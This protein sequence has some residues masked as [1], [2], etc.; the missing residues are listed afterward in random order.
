IAL[1]AHHVDARERHIDRTDLKWHDV[2]AESGERERND[3]KKHHDCAMHRAEDV[4][5]VRL[6]RSVRN[7]FRAE[8]LQQELAN[9]GYGLIR[10]S[11]LPSHQRHEQIAEKQEA[12]SGE[13]ILKADHLVVGGENIFP[14]EAN[15]MMIDIM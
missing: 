11:Q 7:L 3:G 12:Q 5:E 10:I 1:I 9:D 8:D 13:T 15:L 2:V 14:P 6:H 4:V